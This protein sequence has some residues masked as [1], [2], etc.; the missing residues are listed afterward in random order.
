MMVAWLLIWADAQDA[1][2]DRDRG[3]VLSQNVR[4]R[5]HIRDCFDTSPSS[6]RCQGIKD[7]TIFGNIAE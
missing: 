3:E 7:R 4:L 2:M 5:W 6:N 1:L